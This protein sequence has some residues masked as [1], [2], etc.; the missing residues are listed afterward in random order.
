MVQLGRTSLFIY[1][2]HIELVSGLIAEPIK[3]RLPFG[4]AL[5]AFV[6]FTAAMLGVSI[7]KTRVVERRR[8]LTQMNAD[9]RRSKERVR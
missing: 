7:V 8:R 5:A 2:I 3:R 6:L 4:W 9:K 1:W